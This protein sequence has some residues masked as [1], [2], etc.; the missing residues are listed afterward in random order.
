V[1]VIDFAIEDDEV[2]VR[3]VT[4]GLM[5][6]GTEI[7]DSEACVADHRSAVVNNRQ[8]IVIR[9]AVCDAVDHSTSS[10]QGGFLRHGSG[11]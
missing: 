5:S 1:V 10:G 9:A 6:R 11:G 8:P 2:T 4:H 3:L 7:E